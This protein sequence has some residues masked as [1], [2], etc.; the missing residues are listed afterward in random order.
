MYEIS[1]T[2]VIFLLI[3]NVIRI[4]NHDGSYSDVI[5]EFFSSEYCTISSTG[6]IAGV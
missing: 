1:I 6:N 3:G 5:A 4:R 2:E